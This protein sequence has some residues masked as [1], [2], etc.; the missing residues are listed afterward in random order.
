M[1]T[2]ITA[3][4]FEKLPLKKQREI[5]QEYIA[6]GSRAHQA[7]GSIYDLLAPLIG[8]KIVDL[9]NDSSI[10]G[11][12]T[13]RKAVIVPLFKD[14]ANHCLCNLKDS[15]SYA[16]ASISHIQ[17]HLQ[18]VVDSI[19]TMNHAEEMVQAVM[20]MG[21]GIA[22]CMRIANQEVLKQLMD[23]IGINAEGD[24]P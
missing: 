7:L 20:E 13:F 6:L 18:I 24:K 22:R 23:Q 8:E 16:T 21:Y 11:W 4:E 15:D 10:P 9:T 14:L 5:Q 12:A 17:C 19:F 3:E 1:P 2:A